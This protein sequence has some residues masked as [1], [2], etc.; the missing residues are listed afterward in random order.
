MIKLDFFKLS[1]LFGSFALLTIFLLQI[2]NVFSE[3]LSTSDVLQDGTKITNQVN[4][5]MTPLVT[6]P[7]IFLILFFI[8][9]I[10]GICKIK[11]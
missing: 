11:K 6:I 4:Y 8:F 9:F 10:L 3:M 7:V 2:M 5:F 1:S